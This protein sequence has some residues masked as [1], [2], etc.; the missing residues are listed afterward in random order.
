MPLKGANSAGF[1]ASGKRPRWDNSRRIDALARL[2]EANSRLY[3]VL[4]KR[5]LEKLHYV[6]AISENVA[7]ASGACSCRTVYI[8]RNRIPAGTC[9]YA[10]RGSG[11]LSDR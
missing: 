1:N 5:G 9:V 6:V 3:C 7:R 4:E 8:L 10:R 11:P 2:R